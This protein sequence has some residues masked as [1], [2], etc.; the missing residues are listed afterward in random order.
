MG[1]QSNPTLS[2]RVKLCI[3][4]S[5][6]LRLGLYFTMIYGSSF[7]LLSWMKSYQDKLDQTQRFHW[8][9]LWPLPHIFLVFVFLLK[10]LSHRILW[11]LAIVFEL[12]PH[13]LQSIFVVA[14]STGLSVPNLSHSPSWTL[15]LHC[16]DHYRWRNFWMILNPF[17]ASDS[18]VGS[19]QWK[20]VRWRNESKWNTS[21]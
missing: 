4:N 17:W 21:Y 16:D 15:D 10:I 5:F 8:F 3:F 2:L 7:S 11:N 13:V 14:I 9:L 18:N 1:P 6:G 20:K 12:L 19:F